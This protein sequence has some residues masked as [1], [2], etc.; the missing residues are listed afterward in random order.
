MKSR[1]ILLVT[2][3]VCVGMLA[4]AQIKPAFNP[5]KGE[6]YT[7]RLVTDQ[8]MNNSF[9]GKEMT[10]GVTTEILMEL[11]VKEKSNNEVSIE[12]AYKE[13]VTTSSNPMMSFKVDSKNKAGNTS[14][15]EKMIAKLYDCFIGKPLQLIVTPDGS[16][17]S[18]TGYNAIQE[19]LKKVLAS[20][21]DMEQQMAS[22]SIESFTEDAIKSGFEQ[23]F[24]MY[25]DKEIKVG[26]SWSKDISFT[27]A[28]MSNN[29]KNTYMLKSVNNDVALLDVASVLT[30]KPGGGM[31][32]DIKGDQKGEMRLD[33]KT[34][35]PVQSSS[36]GTAKGKMSG[37]GIEMSMEITTI[38][39]VT[40]Q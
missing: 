12:Y 29:V 4:Q 6:K 7:Y 14:E 27:M 38:S 39:S 32:G 10:A 22:M 13:I 5:A 3:L 31:E 15:I 8:K 11:T 20:L 33:L 30:V 1:T 2:A 40:L 34:G 37:Q 24:K 17:K 35:M 21:G 26:D 36:E 25:P 9:S 18:L 28:N 16:V 19:D 23:T